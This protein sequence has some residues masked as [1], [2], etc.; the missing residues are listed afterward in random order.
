MD[1]VYI[2]GPGENEELKYSI[3]SVIKNAPVGKV[4]VVGQSPD[5]YSGNKINIPQDEQKYIN[6]INNLKAICDSKDIS[7]SFILMNDD[8]YIVNPISNIKY[9]YS[10]SLEEKVG[11][12]ID[13]VP[14]SSYT[15]R[16]QETHRRLLKDGV[17]NPL[18]Y[19]LHVPMPMNKANLRQCLDIPKVLWRSMYGNLFNVGG[20]QM[21]DV[22]VYLA[23]AL[24]RNSY[25]LDDLKYDYLSSDDSSFKLIKKTVLEKMFPEPSN[26][27]VATVLELIDEIQ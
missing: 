16:L 13:L 7:D 15:R 3:R 14:N 20:I 1:Y 24:R 4:W 11:K 25:S 19:E 18:D 23:G 22:K 21:P 8:F 12:Y 26:Y 2:C 5:W 10:G 9:M 27:E 17:S 6:A